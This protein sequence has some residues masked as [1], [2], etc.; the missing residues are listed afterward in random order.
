MNFFFLE[1]L[2]INWY[3]EIFCSSGIL[4]NVEWQLVTDVSGQPKG[5]IS[6]GQAVKENAGN[7]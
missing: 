1:A 2:M 3:F 6:E 7:T 4:C 5:P